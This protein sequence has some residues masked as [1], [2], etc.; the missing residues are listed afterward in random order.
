MKKGILTVLTAVF[1]SLAAVADEGMWLPSLIGERIK[2]MRSKGFRLTAEDIYSVNKASMKDAVVLFG[3]GCTGEIVSAEGLLLT[4]HH[5][6]YGAIQS[7]STLDHDYLTY[8]F[9]ARSRDE[10]LPNERLTVR[11]L[12]RMEDVTDRIAA[13]ADK[14]KLIQA[15]RAE[16]PGYDASVEEMYYG[17]QSFLFVYQEFSDVRLVGAPPSSIGKFG[18]DTDNWMWPR[19]TGD[20]SVFRIYAG[21]DNNPAAY[22]PDN[23]PYRPRRHFAI[24]TRGV[25][26]GDFTMIYGFPGSTQQY[27]LSDAVDYVQ[28]LSDPMKIDLRT[29]RLDIIS[30]AQEADPKVRIQYAA[31]HAGIANAWKKWQGE[32]AGL[33]RMNT[34]A[35]KRDYERRFAEWAA[36]KPEYA[37]LLDSMRAAYA[38]GREP[39]FHQELLSES[40][41]S[42]ELYPLVR[43]GV[44]SS[45][46]R[47]GEDDAVAEQRRIKRAAFLKDYDPAVDRALVKSALRGFADYCPEGF[48]AEAQAEID[49]HGGMDAY[50]D[51]VFDHTRML[52]PQ[53]EIE[54]LDSAAVVSDPIYRFVVL[55]DG[56]RAP[57]YYRRNLSNI[58]DIERWYRPYLRALRAFDPDRA[59][60][61]DANLTL[62]VAYG[63][64]AG[65][66]YADGEYHTPQTTLDGI[67]AK[68]NPEIYDYDI[69]QRLRDLYASKE[70]GRW[71]VEIDGRRTV[72]VCFLAS[73]QTTGGNSGSPVLNGRGELI[74][75]N[76]DRT[77][78]STMSDIAFDPTI[79]R[80]IAVDIRYV[81]FVID[82]VGGASYLIDEM[83]VR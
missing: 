16:G 43:H 45:S 67:I 59:F 14:L 9:W 38:R 32:V 46:W 39:Y 57:E 8:G 17:N 31:K 22:S 65:Y 72:P 40:I 13:G 18:G 20:F 21:R 55:F 49:R 23:V 42:L 15:A 37:G 7:H 19:H 3:R 78:R 2:D 12:V 81:L 35:A 51:Y 53:E 41:R 82:K 48:S 61:P 63:T 83:E 24:S 54:R 74:G 1:A 36:D 11:I 75:I 58:S 10:E 69:P 66:E 60:F 26:E 34:L 27:I 33:K 52:L 6:G 56:K 64:V 71:G 70:Y 76:F 44:L 30:A 5:C 25:K 62:R 4:N 50:A 28:N 29:R 80:N 77:W 79:C 73:N 47:R 68:D